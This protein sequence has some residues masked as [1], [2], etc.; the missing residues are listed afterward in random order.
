MSGRKNMMMNIMSMD[1]GM[2]MPM[3]MMRYTQNCI[4]IPAK[5]EPAVL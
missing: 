2:Y 3:S 1:M 4:L 5:P